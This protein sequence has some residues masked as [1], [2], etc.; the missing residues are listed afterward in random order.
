MTRRDD[1]G[2][3]AVETALVL[4]LTVFMVLG[5]VQLSWMMQGRLMAQ[6]AV[7]KATRAGSLNHADCYR[8][9]D[10]AIAALLPVFA[11]TGNAGDLGAAFQTVRTAGFKYTQT[12]VNPF[13]GDVMWMSRDLD[14]VA[15]GNN[16]TLANSEDRFDVPLG[17]IAG[18]GGGAG[19]FVLVTRLLFWFPLKVPFA[20]WVIARLVQAKW[21]L[22]DY[23][24][25]N[26]LM[27][28]QS[29]AGWT[30]QGVRPIKA[31]VSAEL[32]LRIARAEYV[33]PIIVHSSTRM[34][35]PP[36]NTATDTI[37]GTCNGAPPGF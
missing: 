2:Q 35:S 36:R 27:P 26:P 22:R 28:T 16:A 6:Y 14:Q 17:G 34:M 4:P 12:W 10:S 9:R 20:N 1:S 30:A 24:A 29:R 32:N 15:P 3:A 13:S 8:M 19:G 37:P 31:P 21:G 33:V 5:A 18:V 23:D 11:K 7:Y 25:V